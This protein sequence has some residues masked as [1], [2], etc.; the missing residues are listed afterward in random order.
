MLIWWEQIVQ[1]HEHKRIAKLDGMLDAAPQV[2]SF[3]TEYTPAT[4][5]HRA[6]ATRRLDVLDYLLRRH[7]DRDVRG[8]HGQTPL[9]DACWSSVSVDFARHL[10]TGWS[11]LS[12]SENGSRVFAP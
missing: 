10:R 12:C 5:L 2:L 7:M 9:H 4:L 8:M 11:T 3:R 1:S 6:V